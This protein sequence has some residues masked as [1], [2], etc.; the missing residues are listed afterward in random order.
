MADGVTKQRVIPLQF[1]DDLF[2]V[3][4]DQQFVMVE[5]MAVLRIVRAVHSV[6]IKGAR[7]CIGQITVPDLV[8]EFGQLDAL[9]LFLAFSV[10][11]AEF[12]LGGMGGEDCKVYAR[13]V[14]VGAERIRL[15]FLDTRLGFVLELG[16]GGT[17][18]PAIKRHRVHG[19]SSSVKLKSWPDSHERQTDAA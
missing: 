13:T 5:A 19:H 7:A 8:G 1:A 2:G 12:D 18:S 11:Q 6:A 16:L 9:D 14:P 15:A 4:V 3:G 17:R 10:E